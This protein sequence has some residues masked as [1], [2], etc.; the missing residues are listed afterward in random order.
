MFDKID[1]GRVLEGP[2]K[3][4]RLVSPPGLPPFLHAIHHP[5]AIFPEELWGQE[6]AAGVLRK[7]LGGLL[8]GLPPLSTLIHGH[9]GT[10]KTS[11][12]LSLWNEWNRD[13]ARPSL[14]LI[15]ADV[16]GISFIAPLV[17]ILSLR[18]EPYLLLLDDLTFSPN[19]SNFRQFKA[20][21]DG[22]AMAPPD[23][24][25]LVVTTNI[26]NLL[27]ESR[28]ARGDALH[29]EEQTDDTHAIRD[30]FGIV[31]SF[32]EPSVEIYLLIVL[33]KARLASLLPPDAEEAALLAR[34]AD[35]QEKTKETA[36]TSPDPAVRFL[37]AALG[38][39]RARGSRSGRTARQFVD[40]A[41]R[42]L[43]SDIPG[44]NSLNRSS[45][46]DK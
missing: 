26:R 22:G 32:D 33:R 2:H 15:Q 42:G 24:L 25:G 5:R 21:L 45:E 12:V 1:E 9:R 14:R 7:N 3:A 29:E 46:N 18:S 6:T 28:A 23:N 34:L 41:L 4:F 35:W 10:G 40:L 38:Y 16:T 36:A 19:D 8:Q 31:L 27:P 39:S 30:R 43:L 37:L 17:D 13:P 11:L 20:F 44:M